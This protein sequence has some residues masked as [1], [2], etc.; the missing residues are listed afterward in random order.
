MPG[1]RTGPCG[2]S[3]WLDAILFP[4]ESTVLIQ[5]NT[6]HNIDGAEAVTARVRDV[7]AQALDRHSDQITRVEVHL[8]DENSDKKHGVEEM[9]CV[10]EARLEGRPPAAVTHRAG[11]VNQAVFGA[12]EKLERLIEHT[13]GRLRAQENQGSMVPES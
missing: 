7:V 4:P 13:L 5:V 2:S 8:S 1:L 3:R 6:D 11:T 9:R 10:M 12:A